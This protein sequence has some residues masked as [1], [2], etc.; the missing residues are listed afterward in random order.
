MTD[1]SMQDMTGAGGQD[2]G[3]Q[4]DDSQVICT[5]CY[6]RSTGQFSMYQGDEPDDDQGS[7]PGAGAGAAGAA[8]PEAG[9]GEGGEGAGDQAGAEQEAPE[10]E[11]EQFR[12]KADL[13]RAVLE[14][15]NQAEE[16]GGSEEQFSAGFNQR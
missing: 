12:N 6:S 2:Q 8:V 4:E 15:V 9:Q 11:A 3:D 7:E 13:M 16:Q 1:T 10:V 14:V 5:I